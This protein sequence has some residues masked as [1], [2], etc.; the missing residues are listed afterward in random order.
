MWSL[1]HPSTQALLLVTGSPPPFSAIFA[2]PLVSRERS[3]TVICRHLGSLYFVSLVLMSIWLPRE[4]GLI[5]Y[6]ASRNS[7]CVTN[8]QWQKKARNT[9]VRLRTNCDN[10]WLTGNKRDKGFIWLMASIHSI[11]M[12]LYYLFRL[13]T[14]SICNSLLLTPYKSNGNYWLARHHFV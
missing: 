14:F 7:V 11:T 9:S 1:F 4:K 2:L 8:K 6:V 3:T 5:F 12:M 13:I 10:W